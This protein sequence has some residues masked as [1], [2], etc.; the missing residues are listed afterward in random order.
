MHLKKFLS[1]TIVALAIGVLV[2]PASSVFAQDQ[3]EDLNYAGYVTYD[4]R[5]EAG[6][7]FLE[8]YLAA[9]EGQVGVAAV[10]DDHILNEDGLWIPHYFGPY[11]N[12]TLSP[13]PTV[14]TDP[15]T[16]EVLS[17][18]GGIRKFIDSLP[19]LTSA[20]QNN[21]GQYLPVAVPDTT[22]YPGTDYYVIAV[23]EVE[24]QLHT[25]LPPTKLRQYVQLSTSVVPGAHVAL[26][27]AD[28]NNILMP[29]GSQAYGV[30]YSHYLGPVI[31]AQKDRAVR[32]KFHNLLP[33][34][35]GGDLFI[36]VDT[37][38]M[39]AGMG[40]VMNMFTGEDI[41]YTQN[42]ATLHLHG[43]RTPWISDGTPH[44]WITPAGEDTPYPQ[45]VSVYHVPDMWFDSNGNEVPA[46]TPGATNDP[47][48]GS[49]TFFYTNQQSGRFMFYH[50]HSYGITRLN[51]YAG[52]AAGYVIRDDVELDLIARGIIPEDEIPLIIQDKTFV[53]DPSVPFSNIFGDWES[54]GAF[55]DPTWDPNR[56]GDYGD[57]WYP[58]VYMTVQNPFVLSGINAFGKWHYGPWFWPPTTDIPHQPVPNPYADPANAGYSP[59]EPPYI[60][61]VPTNSTGMESFFDTP[62]VNGTVYP[63][64]EVDPKTYR[65]RILNAANDRFWNLQLYVADPDVVTY[66][67]RSNT[68]VRMVDAAPSPTLPEGWPVDGRD[69]GIP[70]PLMVGPDMIQIGTEGGFLPEP[71][72]LPSQPLK[73]NLDVTTFDAGNVESGTLMLGPAER[74]DVIIDFSAFAGQTLILYNDA[75]APWPAPAPEFDYYTGAEDYSETGGAPGTEPGWGPNTR[76]IMQIRVADV[77]PEAAYDLGALESEFVPGDGNGVFVRGQD[78][79][80]VGQS[81]YDDVYATTFPGTWPYWGYSNIQNTTLS[82]ETVDGDVVDD[83]PMEP[84]AIQDEMGETFDE[85]GRMSGFLGLQRRIHGRAGRSSCCSVLPTH[86]LT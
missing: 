68:E 82:F 17:V 36:P 80:I 12:Y 35:A 51:V 52:G 69:G 14:V 26:V 6:Q 85:Y 84:K 18:T 34:G 74:A 58:H 40:P 50:D 24:E 1:R 20:K 44:Q 59:L 33:T 32:V 78:E 31:V 38:V 39:G 21:L 46:G 79:I 16:G 28:G 55:Y 47:G 10:S 9:K 73:W 75:P 37:T 42:R 53:P 45:G 2:L 25:D 77:D 41:Y 13:L 19:G 61:G 56:W 71:V 7:R 67:G 8:A 86:R 57:L 83:F 49:M 4:E 29:D 54:Q 11:P 30:D 62:V 63:Y 23:V 3:D 64:L 27:D 70:D 5:Q 72:V 81:A 22:T 76:T 60:P 43:G 48:D 66:D 15:G 65:F